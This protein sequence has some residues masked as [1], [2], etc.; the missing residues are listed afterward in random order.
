MCGSDKIIPVITGRNKEEQNK[1]NPRENTIIKSGAADEFSRR[2]PA[3]AYIYFT[4]TL[5]TFGI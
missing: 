5:F 3:E 1:M 4:S 2:G